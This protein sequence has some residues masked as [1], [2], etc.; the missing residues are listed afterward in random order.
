MI[1]HT[2]GPWVIE[3]DDTKEFPAINVFGTRPL[4]H[5]SSHPA[6][7]AAQRDAKQ[8]VAYVFTPTVAVGS[9]GG[10]RATLETIREALSNAVLIA[11]GPEMY[12]LLHDF[13]AAWG[14]EDKLCEVRTRAALLIES[15]DEVK[16]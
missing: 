8:K 4:I 2:A 15:M 16:L 10:Q 7:R 12:A 9:R 6:S 11:N 3:R 14:D 13:V 1:K 5:G